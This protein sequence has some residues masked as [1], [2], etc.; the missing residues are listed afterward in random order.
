MGRGEGGA[1]FLV[2]HKLILESKTPAGASFCSPPRQATQPLG[3]N[4]HTL[5]QEQTDNPPWAA[6]FVLP[7]RFPLSPSFGGSSRTSWHRCNLLTF[8]RWKAVS[9]EIVASC[10]QFLGGPV[11]CS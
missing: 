7:W 4:C 8:P 5:H 1:P 2:L 3:A 11:M 9:M 10:K 6:E